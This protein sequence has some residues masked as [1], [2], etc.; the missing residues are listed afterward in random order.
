MMSAEN[1]MKNNF[2]RI[3]YILLLSLLIPIY[4]CQ[5]EEELLDRVIATVNDGIIMQS[6]LEQKISIV[7]EQLAANGTPLP[8]ES[9]LRDQVLN[10]LI[11]ESIQKQIAKE[12]GIR[13]SDSQ[14]N[15]ALER[16][17]GNNSLTLEQFRDALIAEGRDYANVREQIRT[18]LLLNNVKQTLINQRIHVSEQEIKNFLKST[19][20][21]KQLS[22]EIELSHI[23]IATPSQASPES[24]QEAQKEAQ[25]IYEK[26]KKG[27]DFNQMAVEH[28][29]AA[30]ALNGGNL[31]WRRLNELPELLAESVSK[32]APGE[33]SQPIRSPS[34]FHLLL[35][36]NKRGGDLGKAVEERLVSHIL[37]KPNQVRDIKLAQR[38][39]ERLYQRIK[40][41]E[42]FAKLAKKFSDDPIS[43]S[44]GGSLGWVQLGQMV[45]TFERVMND[46]PKGA[47]SEPFKSRFGWHILTVKDVRTQDLSTEIKESRAKAAIRQ[48]KFNEELINWLREIRSQAYID[49]KD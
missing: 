7:K 5:A 43:G 22:S 45:P 46:T 33:I 13:V 31:G 19:E 25:S 23:L 30:N 42:D 11:L 49:I 28:S 35:V 12:N 1:K 10:R 16:I 9:I 44:E 8:P 47:V 18:E 34:G 32:L 41:G 21:E 26:L 48:R 29:D 2:L 14:L 15:Q 17:A 37:L 6:E 38:Q 4:S 39:I 20:G 27:T 3:L 40:K 24:I 36:K